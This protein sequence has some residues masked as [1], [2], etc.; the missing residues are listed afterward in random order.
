LFFHFSAKHGNV[1]AMSALGF[2]YRYGIGVDKKC[3]NA[4][5]YYYKAAKRSKENQNA[6]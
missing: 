3:S 4:K 2:A 5:I 6:G 1:P